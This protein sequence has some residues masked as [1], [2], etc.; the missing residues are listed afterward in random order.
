MIKFLDIYKQDKKFHKKILKDLNK[1]FRKG[2]FIL[3]SDVQNFEKHF[4]TFCNS[5][6]S[7]GCAN[8]TDALT[9]SLKSLDLQQTSDIQSK[10]FDF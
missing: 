4:A 1:T 3:G 7:I 8:G 2:D 10:D 9:I 5:Q 6:Y